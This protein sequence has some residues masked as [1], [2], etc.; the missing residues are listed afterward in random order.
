MTA[1]ISDV[2]ATSGL[3]PVPLLETGGEEK[4]LNPKPWTSYWDYDSRTRRPK[5]KE[6]RSE[7]NPDMGGGQA[8]QPEG[9]GFR[10]DLRMLTTTTTHSPKLT[11]KPQ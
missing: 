11:W 5:K 3:N 4:S 10:E 1:L 8:L 2:H 9:L 6:E 7:V